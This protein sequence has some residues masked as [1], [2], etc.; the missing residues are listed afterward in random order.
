MGGHILQKSGRNLKIL[1]AKRVTLSV[2][3]IE[4]L[5]ILGVIVNHL[6]ATVTC[7]PGFLH[8]FFNN[9]KLENILGIFDVTID[10]N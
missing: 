5:Q 8:C 9:R 4:D 3:H 2:F 7:R 1:G 6:F 10:F